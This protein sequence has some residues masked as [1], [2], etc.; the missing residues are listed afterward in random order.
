[1]SVKII[2][3]WKLFTLEMKENKFTNCRGEIVKY[4]TNSEEWWW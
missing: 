1:M 4:T 2:F 3:R